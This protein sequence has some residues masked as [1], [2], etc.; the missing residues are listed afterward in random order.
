MMKTTMPN[1]SPQGTAA[2]PKVPLVEATPKKPYRRPRLT[3]LG[4]LKSVAGSGITW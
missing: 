2:Q 1:P 3:K 4:Q